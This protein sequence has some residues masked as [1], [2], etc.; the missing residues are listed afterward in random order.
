ML[1]LQLLWAQLFVLFIGKIWA[2]RDN[3]LVT[4]PSFQRS[5]CELVFHSKWPIRNHSCSSANRLFSVRQVGS[6]VSTVGK[7]QPAQW[8]IATD[9]SASPS[10]VEQPASAGWGLVVD[11][12][13]CLSGVEVEC[14]GEVLTDDRDPRPQG[15]T[16][17][18]IT[19]EN[20]GLL[21]RF[22][23]GCV[24]SRATTS[25]FR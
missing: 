3:R 17:L 20:F 7:P 12:V 23:F 14:W 16:L 24:T 21:R 22:F 25:L 10:P 9:G 18:L 4:K 11:R 6:I 2:I 15:L 1:C 13:G 19:Q 5:R 8:L